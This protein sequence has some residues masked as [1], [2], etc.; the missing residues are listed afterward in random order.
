MTRG[1]DDSFLP[2]PESFFS[3]AATA[4]VLVNWTIM[5]VTRTQADI[6]VKFWRTW[7][8]ARVDS[9][10][11]ESIELSSS[12]DFSMISTDCMSPSSSRELQLFNLRE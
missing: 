4:L 7:P 3:L 2:L 8:P 11:N 10:T 1:E 9:L 6:V 12:R 5:P